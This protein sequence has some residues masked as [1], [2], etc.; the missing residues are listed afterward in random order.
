MISEVS[1]VV[2]KGCSIRIEN[3][4]LSEMLLYQ[5]EKYELRKAL[6]FF[7]RKKSMK[8]VLA[9]LGYKKKLKM[10]N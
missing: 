10:K 2:T 1:M 5:R 6:K 7:Y 8:F 3:R 4:S 9:V